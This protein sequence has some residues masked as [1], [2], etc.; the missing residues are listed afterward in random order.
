LNKIVLL[1]QNILDKD[2]DKA[3]KVL[4]H[5]EQLKELSF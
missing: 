3:E 4:R 1:I 5:E 2:L